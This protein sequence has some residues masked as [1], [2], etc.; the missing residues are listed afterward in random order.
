MNKQQKR[1][2]NFVRRM[3]LNI[4]MFEELEDRNS[5]LVGFINSFTLNYIVS[6]L[7]QVNRQKFIDLLEH[8]AD[9]DRV[10]Q[11][12]RK[13]IKNFDENYEKQLENKLREIKTQTLNKKK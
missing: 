9:D 3:N 4:F 1:L 8:E 13:H 2:L 12:V 6:R 7:N 10:W 5:P 11:F